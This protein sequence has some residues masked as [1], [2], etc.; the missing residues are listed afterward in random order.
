MQHWTRRLFALAMVSTLAACGGSDEITLDPPQNIVQIAQTDSRFTVLAEAVVAADLATAL[1]A[2]GPLTVFAPT[3]DAFNALL[4]ELGLTK[5]QLLANKP[6]L[7]AVLQY[8]VLGSRVRRADVPLG[9]AITPL[10]GGIFKVDN[11]SG[12]LVITDGRNRTATITSTDIS[13]A[14]GVIHVIDKVLLPANRNIV[15]TAIASAPEFSILVEAVVA[16]NL[17]GTLSS[18]GP[19][20]VF[21]PT[22]AAFAALLTELGTSKEALFADTALLTKVLTYHVVPGRVLRADVPVGPAITTVNG[23]TLTVNASLAITDRRS[24]TAN[25]TAT[26]VL[27]SNGVIHVVDRVILP[28]DITLSTQRNIVTQAQA[29]PQF[30][31]LVEAVVAANLQGTLSGTGPFTVFAPTNAAFASLLTELGL[32]KAQLLADVPL[33]T[34]VLQY[35]VLGGQVLRAQVPAGQAITPL[36]GGIFKVDAVSGALVVNDG[37]NRK[38]N[39]TATDM[40]TSNGVIHAIDKVLLPANRNIVETAIASA[41]EFSILVEAVVAANLQGTLSGTG[42]FTVFAPTNAAF[43]SL[44]TELG[45][46]K[47]ALLA[48]TALLTQVLTYHVVPGR[49]L[50]AGVPVGPSI[51][52]VQGGSFTVNSTLAIT[53]ARGRR[54]NITGTDVLTSNGVIHVI[55]K[56]ILPA[57]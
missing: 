12:A 21:A 26:D 54:S 20:T 13:A 53:D 46:T 10:A 17:Q 31:I 56:V 43:A 51:T 23:E 40:R 36:A 38:A 28:A 4:T 57:P 41:P 30:S 22:N 18:T 42:P 35:H 32:T 3:N 50:K 1:S 33:L 11:R 15:E 9:R 6:L 25:I 29:L 48:N 5:A 37:R 8:H 52:T 24:R 45:V 2:P 39:I 34:A 55:D 47:E 27:T 7:T 14:N 49:V 16:A 19:F 44:L